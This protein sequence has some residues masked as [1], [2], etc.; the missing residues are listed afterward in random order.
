LPV[1]VLYISYNALEEPLV[2]SQVLPYLRLLVSKGFTFQLIT[3]ERKG[4][5]SIPARKE[6]E[7]GIEWTPIA[8]TGGTVGR[9]KALFF[10]WRL[11]RRAIRAKQIMLLHARS[12]IPAMIANRACRG[13]SVPWLFD[14][15]GF[16]VDEKVLKG[17]LRFGSI[18]YRVLKSIERNLL[19]N[20]SAIVSLTR[21]AI[22]RLKEISRFSELPPY[23]VIPTCVDLDHFKNSPKVREADDE[24]T[25][26]YVGSL[27]PGYA[28]DDLSQI[29]DYVLDTLPK[30]R[31]LI[32]SR[33]DPNLLKPLLDKL[34]RFG[35]R[36]Q[37]T[38]ASY[39]EMPQKIGEMDVGLSFITQHHSKDASAPTKIAEYLACGVFVIS[40]RGIGDIDG[41]LEEGNV[42]VSIKWPEDIEGSVTLALAAVSEGSIRDRCRSYAEE[43]FSV[44]EGAQKYAD[45]Y[46]QVIDRMVK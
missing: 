45:L 35:S 16:W 33:S 10:A 39:E 4:E 17:N 5:P 14:M 31:A 7:N 13:T 21:K 11:V 42:G 34:S 20:C 22:P 9:T 28:S 23:A 36:V 24:I 1:K 8:Q 29:L 25:F 37:C 43:H 38:S 30:S 41:I 27:G 6:L 32:L 19:Q 2:Q 26:G 44:S 40:N 3:F 15:R 46:R 12:Y 18:T